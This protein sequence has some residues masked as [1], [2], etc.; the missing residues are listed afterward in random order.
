MAARDQHEA[1]AIVGMGKTNLILTSA[2]RNVMLKHVLFRM[3]M[4]RRC[5]QRARAVGVPQ[6]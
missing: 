5:P 2:R 4:A 1:V 3:S 6:E